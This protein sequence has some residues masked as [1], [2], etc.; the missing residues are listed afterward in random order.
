MLPDPSSRISKGVELVVFCRAVWSNQIFLVAISTPYASTAVSLLLV[1]LI[2]T[3]AY[4]LSAVRSPSSEYLM[5]SMVIVPPVSVK[6][7]NCFSFSV[8]LVSK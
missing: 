3:T 5:S 1:K 2:S 6:I 8:N 4:E 7:E